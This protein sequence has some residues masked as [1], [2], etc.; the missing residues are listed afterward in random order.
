MR[1]KNELFTTTRT[2]IES[3]M[4]MNIFHRCQPNH[5]MSQ[6][7]TQ[8]T[9]QNM[10]IHTSITVYTSASIVCIRILFFNVLCMYHKQGGTRPGVTLLKQL[11]KLNLDFFSC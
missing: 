10:M 1:A 8:V 7:D 2:Q 3:E 11:L 6:T 5:Q 4:E 9:Q